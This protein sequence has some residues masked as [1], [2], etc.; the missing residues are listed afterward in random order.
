MTVH[1]IS[2]SVLAQAESMWE[3]NGKSEVLTVKVQNAESKC[4]GNGGRLYLCHHA[5]MLIHQCW[6]MWATCVTAFTKSYI[7]LQAYM[8]A[9]EKWLLRTLFS[10]GYTFKFCEWIT[11]DKKQIKK[12][13][14]RYVKLEKVLNNVFKVMVYSAA[15]GQTPLLDLFHFHLPLQSCR[16]VR[17][18]KNLVIS[19]IFSK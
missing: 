13:G 18:C 3:A 14:W 11:I 4:A 12:I 15:G 10:P 17:S 9:F 5:S 8:S 7:K 19:N 16:T 1:H 6:S 2:K